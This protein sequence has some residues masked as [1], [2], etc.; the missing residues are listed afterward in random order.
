[1]S[2]IVNGVLV[3]DRSDV[4]PRRVGNKDVELTA[5]EKDATLVEW[6]ANETRGAARRLEDER[7]AK[8]KAEEKAILRKQAEDALI[9]RNEL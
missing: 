4:G 3:Y 7:E 9:A 8:I 1:M 6:N 5:A 2:K